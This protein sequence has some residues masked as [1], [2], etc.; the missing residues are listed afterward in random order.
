MHVFG[1]ISGPLYPFTDSEKLAV[2]ENCCLVVSD[3]LEIK[4]TID[5]LKVIE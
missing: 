4:Q 2:F 1:K 5:I 3:Y